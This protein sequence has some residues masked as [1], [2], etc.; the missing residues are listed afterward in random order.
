MKN[1]LPTHPAAVL[2]LVFLATI[3]LGTG[4]LMLPW[5]TASGQSA[6]WLTA[7][8]WMPV[9]TP[10]ASAAGLASITVSARPP[11]QASR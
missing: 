5:A 6:P 3:V 2:A 11:V 8:I 10:A 1:H 7:F 4:L 9:A